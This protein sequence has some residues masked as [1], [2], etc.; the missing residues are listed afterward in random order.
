[1]FFRPRTNFHQPLL[2]L[3]IL[4]SSSLLGSGKRPFDFGQASVRVFGFLLQFSPNLVQLTHLT[5]CFFKSLSCQSGLVSKLLQFSAKPVRDGCWI[6]RGAKR[7]TIEIRICEGAVEPQRNL[8]RAYE[9][10][11][12]RLSI[13]SSFM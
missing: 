5:F 11:Q 4:L 6:G 9:R 3:P 8:S 7:P 1:L 2:K 12:C 10:P 13:T